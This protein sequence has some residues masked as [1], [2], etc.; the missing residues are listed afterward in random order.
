MK[1]N[2]NN[3]LAWCFAASC[4]LAA[5]ATHAATNITVVNPESVGLLPRTGTIDVNTNAGFNYGAASVTKWLDISADHNVA[6]CWSDAGPVATDFKSM[7]SVWTLFN[8]SGVKLIPPTV[9]TNKTVAVGASTLTN[10]WLAFFRPDGSST[11]G[12]ASATPRI[13]A[14][15]FGDGLLFGA[16]ADRLGL[17]I[18]AF[19]DINSD[20]STGG[21]PLTTLSTASGFSAVQLINNNGAPGAGIVTGVNDAEA[22]ATG[23]VWCHGMEVLANGNIVIVSESR[24]DQELVDRFGGTTPNRHVIYRVVTPAGGVVKATS[25]ASETTDRTEL[26]G[27]GVGVTANGFAIRFSYRPRHDG[28]G[29]TSGTIRLFDNDGNPISGDI[30][31]S[32]AVGAFLG[33]GPN[34]P[35]GG[36]GG[37]GDS[38]GFHGNGTDAY[39][40]AC[41]GDQEGVRGPVY[42]T[43]YNADG[44]VRYH[45]AVAD[46]GETTFAEQVDAAISPDGRVIVVMDDNKVSDIT[47][48]ANRL[49]LGRIFDSNGDPMGPAFYVSEREN[50]FIATKD[51]LRPKVAWRDNIVAVAWGSSNS[52]AASSVVS[53][54]I[55]EVTR[56]VSPEHVGLAPR[57]GTV[58][59]NANSAF[60]YGNPGFTDPFVDIT[61]NHNAAVCFGDSTSPNTDFKSMN[62]V[63]TLYD[64]NGNNLIAP[65]VITNL[66][67]AVGA[68]TLTNNWLAFFRPNG[69]STPGNA[70]ATSRVRASRFGNGFMFGARGDRIGLEIPALLAINTDASSGGN[71]LTTL[72]GSSG[73]PVVQLINNDGTPGAGIVT[74]MNEAEA[75]ASGNVFCH[76]MEVLANGNIVIASES[77]Q[78]QELVDRFGGTTPNRHVVYRVVTPAGVVVKPTSLVSETF[79]R[80]ELFGFGIGVTSNGFAIRFSYRPRHDGSGKTSG[81][82]R[83]FDNN[84]NPVSGDIN[85]SDAVGAFL[86][87]GPNN[88]T[89]GN[90][91][92]GDS[93]GFGGNYKDAYVNACIGDQEGVRGPVYVTVY[94]ADGSVRYHRPVAEPGETNRANSVSAAIHADGRVF[95]AMDDQI[96]SADGVSRLIV[97]K[98]FDPAGNSMGPLFYVSELETASLATGDTQGPRVAWRDHYIACVW[99][100]LNGPPATP[101]VVGFR[102]F[103]DVATTPPTLSIANSGGNAIITWPAT[104]A[105]Y[106]LRSKASVS[107]A[108]WETNSPAPVFGGGGT[109]YQVTEPIGSTTRIYQLIK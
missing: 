62:A 65:T 101:T 96:S 1:T 76:G 34:N 15:R 71:P 80:T 32:D 23:N 31:Q 58:Y 24:Q 25:L 95:V 8:S 85:L 6:I 35:T 98:M 99:R 67:G 107:A 54:R 100:S 3:K 9:I 42:V 10:N 68:P 83:L 82:I 26:F 50:P 63:W 104:A 81:T 17:E 93:V 92:R 37:R 86:G 18:P 14:N 79:D 64:G 30:N 4:L 56:V 47:G 52:P 77:R 75:E 46:A 44:T 5:S 13:R 49:I 60:N 66:T 45:R 48:Q 105:G 103:N 27:F 89:G 87:T 97:G 7:N 29:R 72:S 19:L 28:S 57:H 43:V 21:N 20:N 51:S 88:P 102:M 90:G 73:F 38:V 74:G 70:V 108:N 53:T 109:V 84:G 55:F 33:S 94:N 61:A 39:V 2:M 91:G 40:N 22:Q 12:N 16:R 41:I 36:N 78:D 59:V 106:T 11:P 69:S